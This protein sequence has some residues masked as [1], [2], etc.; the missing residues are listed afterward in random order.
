AGI[1]HKRRNAEDAGTQSEM[2]GAAVL[3]RRLGLRAAQAVISVLAIAIANFL[4]LR[5]VPGDVA[6]VIAGE[7]GSATPEYMADLRSR[8]GLDLS[9]PEQLW[10]YVSRLVQLDLG[11]SF[12]HNMPVGDLILDRLGPTLLLVGAAILISVML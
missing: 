11:H 2:S 1:D 8:F 12:R 9:F 7:S 6:D 4:L 10:L 3:G 5:L